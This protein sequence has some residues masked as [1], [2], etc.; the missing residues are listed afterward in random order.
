MPKITVIV[1]SW[2]FH[3]ALITAIICLKTKDLVLVHFLDIFSESTVRGL[4]Y[5]SGRFPAF[6]QTA[7]YVEF[8]LKIWKI[9][10]VK[11]ASKGT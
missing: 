6:K 5:S 1:D 10:S 4:I 9:M 2:S 8:I 11:P 3:K 7:W